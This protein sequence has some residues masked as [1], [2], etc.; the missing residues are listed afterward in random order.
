MTTY[1]AMKNPPA[2]TEIDLITRVM[3]DKDVSINSLADQT[4]IPY[5]TLRRSLKGNRP[6]NL[7]E[8]RTIA[9]TLG[10]HPSELLPEALRGHQEAA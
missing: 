5:A 1:K 7:L 2:Q 6:L 8:L 4:S 10:V 3:A 9:G